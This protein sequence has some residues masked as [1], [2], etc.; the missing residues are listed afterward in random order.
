[1]DKDASFPYQAGDW[2]YIP[3]VISGILAGQEEFS[4]KVLSSDGTVRD[5]R[6]YVKGL[7]EE[8]KHIVTEGCLMNYYAAAAASSE[9]K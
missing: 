3:G 6:L 8:E 5:L 1:M 9:N 7:S 2:V 4:A